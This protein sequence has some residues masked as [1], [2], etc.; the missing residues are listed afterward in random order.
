MKMGGTAN[1]T[2]RNTEESYYSPLSKTKTKDE[3]NFLI[4]CLVYRNPTIKL[5]YRSMHRP[6][7]VNKHE[8]KGK[9]GKGGQMHEGLKARK[10]KAP[11][12]KSCRMISLHITDARDSYLL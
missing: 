9:R 8:S 5:F 7:H 4:N 12:R 2:K 10:G 1:P 6:L 3:E 11:Q